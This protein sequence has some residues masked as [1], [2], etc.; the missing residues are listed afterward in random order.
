L[1]VLP[2]LRQMYTPER[3]LR[4]ATT[5]DLWT[6]LL[7]KR[8]FN[9][10]KPESIVRDL[11]AQPLLWKKFWLGWLVFD[12]EFYQKALLHEERVADGRGMVGFNY[13]TKTCHETSIPHPQLV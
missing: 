9:S 8:H 10:F 12:L 7:L 13:H 11:Y 5:Q 2:F 1:N 4:D 6:A 3:S